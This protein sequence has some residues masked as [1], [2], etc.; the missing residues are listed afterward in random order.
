MFLTGN[1]ILVTGGGT[2]IGR[3]L[4]EALQARGNTVIIAGR[5]EAML[6]ETVAANPG[7]QSVRLDV[8]DP[9]S[10]QSVAARLIADFPDLNMLINSAGAALPDDASGEID[11][12][13]MIDIITTNV[14]G[15][16]RM[17]SAVVEHFKRQPRAA[18][19]HV[20]SGLGY[21]PYAN[22]AVYSAS[23]AALHSYVLSQRYRLRGTSVAVIEI[24]P[25]LVATALAG[26]VASSRAMPLD[27]Y[28]AETMAEL[29]RGGDE[30]L[31]ASSRARRDA[32]L[33]NEL[34]AMNQF[35]DMMI[36]EG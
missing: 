31:V 5:R 2:G 20:T 12:K 11:D 14:Y 35:N 18:L 33:N 13:A 19:V 9:A 7:M 29:E 24:A 3:G 17:S 4:A 21:L 34:E 25:P 23:K 28:I 27:A 10:I 16:I 8:A 22:M 26:N 30:A 6:A 1:T 15:P 32:L 36:G